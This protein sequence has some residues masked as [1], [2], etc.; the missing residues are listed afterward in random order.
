M[1][2]RPYVLSDPPI[3]DLQSPSLSAASYIFHPKDK[4]GLK[5][6]GGLVC[7][8]SGERSYRDLVFFLPPPLS[9]GHFNHL[10]SGSCD[11]A[12]S[13]FFG[14]IEELLLP[15]IQAWPLRKKTNLFFPPIHLLCVCQTQRSS[16]GNATVRGGYGKRQDSSLFF[17]TLIPRTKEMEMGG[18]YFR[19]LSVGN[20]VAGV[21]G[22]K[23][24]PPSPSFTVFFHNCV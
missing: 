2:D 23:P 4:E 1:I 11:I 3:C 12:H 15:K 17:P 9:P 20:C 22:W 24:P 10:E 8:L 14:K 19:F 16:Q 5:L 13:G 21:F 18:G 7:R 6:R